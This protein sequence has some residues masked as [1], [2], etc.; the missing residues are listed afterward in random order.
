MLRA[1]KRRR[2]FIYS[3]VH[4]NC[5]FIRTCVFFTASFLHTGLRELFEQQAG[6]V[7]LF[8]W[9]EWLKEE[10][11]LLPIHHSTLEEGQDAGE[12]EGDEEE[13][14]GGPVVMNE[15]ARRQA[16]LDFLGGI[17]VVHGEP[18]TE[19]KVGASSGGKGRVGPG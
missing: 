2:H 1:Q 15:A 16:A 18:Y 5:P 14:G 9:I 10:L 12:E 8:Q 4:S 11:Q 13:N 17:E 7:V 19:R 3:F 6:E